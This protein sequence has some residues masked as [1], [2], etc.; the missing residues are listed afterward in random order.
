MPT[1]FASKRPSRKRPSSPRKRSTTRYC[2]RRARLGRPSIVMAVILEQRRRARRTVGSRADRRRRLAQ[3]VQS[4][5]HA[6]VGSH[7]SRRLVRLRARS[8]CRGTRGSAA[9]RVRCKP[10]RSST[11]NGRCEQPKASPGQFGTIDSARGSRSASPG[12]IRWPRSASSSRC[13]WECDREQMLI[14]IAA[15]YGRLGRRCGARVGARPLAPVVGRHGERAHGSR[16]QG[17]GARDRAG[18][19]GHAGAI[20]NAFCSNPRHEAAC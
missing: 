11:P 5:R 17:S 4:G 3:R 18:I 20:S 9:A 1:V 2:Y 10:S 19:P 7:R 13:R 12:T 15:S 16:A 14:V 6:R 8:R